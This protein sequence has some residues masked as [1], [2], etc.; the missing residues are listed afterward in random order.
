ME[1]ALLDHLEFMLSRLSLYL[2]LAKDESCDWDRLEAD[3][4]DLESDMARVSIYIDR[5]EE[6]L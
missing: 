4:N 6:P 3:C 1:V 2:K 5:P